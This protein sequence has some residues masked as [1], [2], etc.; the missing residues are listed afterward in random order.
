MNQIKNQF[1]P[2]LRAVQLRLEGA[3]TLEKVFLE[4]RPDEAFDATIGFSG[5]RG[6]DY[7]QPGAASCARVAVIRILMSALLTK[8]HDII[9][10]TCWALINTVLKQAPAATFKAERSE[11]RR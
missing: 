7:H 4:R 11:E 1:Q 9:R 10:A 5:R 2:I 8:Y 3:D 6:G